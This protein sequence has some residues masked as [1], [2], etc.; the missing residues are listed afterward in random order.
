MSSVLHVQQKHMH[1]PKQNR[2]L[3]EYLI[4]DNDIKEAASEILSAEWIT[5]SFAQ[6]RHRESLWVINIFSIWKG[7]DFVAEVEAQWWSAPRQTAF[8]R[9]FWSE[10]FSSPAAAFLQWNKQ[11]VFCCKDV[12]RLEGELMFFFFFSNLICADC[13]CLVK[14]AAFALKLNESFSSSNPVCNTNCT[15]VSSL[16]YATIINVR[17]KWKEAERDTLYMKTVY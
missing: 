3:A 12:G 9:S 15:A 14:G 1:E 5:V 13:F 10:G 11:F 17:G 4:I 8:I 2:T 7:G 6:L 16:C